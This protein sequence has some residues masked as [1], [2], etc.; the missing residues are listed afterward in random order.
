M[1]DL[2]D[3]SKA[4]ELK[5][6][7]WLAVLARCFQLQDALAV[8]ELDRVLDASPEELDQHRVGLKA[9]R[10]NRLDLITRSTERFLT[11]MDDAAETANSK[12]LLH[13]IAARAV[14]GSTNEVTTS[15]VR[16]RVRLG[17]ESSRNSVEATRWVDAVVA[18]KDKVLETGADGVDA[19]GRLGG[20]TFDRARS[21][22]DKLSLRIAG[23]AL[24]RRGLGEIKDKVAD[25][26][27]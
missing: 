23:G 11:R 8:L 21:M 14:V 7:E 19:A 27:T 12:V 20:E 5:A 25:D 2:A 17:I 3:A 13:P 4:A 26:E 15:V 22:T 10:Q 9:A 16:F 1:G 18:V 6:Q 24:R